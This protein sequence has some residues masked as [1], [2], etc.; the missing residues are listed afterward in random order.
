[1]KKIL[2][3]L[4]AVLLLAP[5]A[6]SAFAVT[7]DDADVWTAK[8]SGFTLRIPEAYREAKGLITFSDAGEGM[9][10]GS[11]I[12]MSSAT[13][14]AMPTEEYN[15]L[16]EEELEAYTS[17]DID[18]LFAVSDKL[19]PVEWNLFNIYGINRDRGEAELRRFLLE[20]D[21]NP[22]YFNG[23]EE[24]IA[25]VTAMHENMSFREIGEKDGLRYFVCS[26]DPEDQITL[27]AAGQSDPS[28]LNEFKSLSADND[29]LGGCVDLTGGVKLAP[30]AVTGSRL[31]FETTDLEGKP[32]KS[33]EIFSG[34]AVTM[35]NMWATWC[36]P[37]K[38]EL[39]A[40]AEMAESYEKKGCR[41]IG[42]CLDAEDE[43]TMA[44]ARQ[45]LKEAGVSYLNIV[46]FEGRSELLPNKLYP[47]TYFV[48]ENGTILDGTVYGAQLSK[49]PLVLEKLLSQPVPES[50]GD[51]KGAA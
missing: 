45:I 22:D 11:G 49:Y 13:Y 8:E 39:P 51:G 9:N 32:I 28:W 18:A 33:E 44:E 3:I 37:C 35:I 19:S 2:S 15:A 31:V 24:L 40:L 10:P 29:S 47:T 6:G 7:D 43:E 46:P 34:H 5:A 21:L 36:D 4:L 16:K 14:V 1:M 27:R 17:G 41:I 30:A 12:V 20:K 23:D 50:D 48:D 26:F 38:E 25:A 42:L